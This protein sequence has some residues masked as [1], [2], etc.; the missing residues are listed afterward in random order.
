MIISNLPVITVLAAAFVAGFW[1]L[2]R[3]PPNAYIC[4]ARTSKK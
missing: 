4:E 1:K 2:A 3:N